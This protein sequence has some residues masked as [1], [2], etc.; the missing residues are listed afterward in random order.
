MREKVALKESK[1]LEIMACSKYRKRGKWVRGWMRKGVK[2]EWELEKK[3][4]NFLRSRK[5]S[6]VKHKFL[7]P[8]KPFFFSSGFNLFLTHSSYFAS[9][10]YPFWCCVTN[11]KLFCI[12]QIR[13]FSAICDQFSWLTDRN[14]IWIILLKDGVEINN[15]TRLR[16]LS[17]TKSCLE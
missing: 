4:L 14:E 12:L 10:V 2:K 9:V 17:E 6:R 3:N 8:W 11:E 13:Q 1:Q 5:R 15:F 7:I 16:G